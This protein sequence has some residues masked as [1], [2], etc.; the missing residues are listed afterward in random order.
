MM[1]LCFFVLTFYSILCYKNSIIEFQ[2]WDVSLF[3]PE[4]KKC[5]NHT[6]SLLR[7]DRIK[8]LGEFQKHQGLCLAE[9]VIVK[10]GQSVLEA[11]APPLEQAGQMKSFRVFVE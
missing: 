1:L 7:K 3:F 2:S 9:Q 5:I 11:R 10:T 8:Y 6:G 4:V